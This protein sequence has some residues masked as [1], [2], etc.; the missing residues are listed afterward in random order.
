MG[1]KRNPAR[2]MKHHM[3]VPPV[4][5]GAKDSIPLAMLAI[6]ENWSAD[7]GARIV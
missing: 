6:G 4:P 7:C 3:L 2:F 5:T 1:S